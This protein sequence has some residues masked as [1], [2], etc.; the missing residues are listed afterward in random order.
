MLRVAFTALKIVGAGALGGA[1][2]AAVLLLLS[3]VVQFNQ[4]PLRLGVG[5]AIVGFTLLGLIAAGRY[6]YWESRSRW[7]RANRSRRPN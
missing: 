3:L 2:V 7:T 6:I 1:F 4:L 5:L